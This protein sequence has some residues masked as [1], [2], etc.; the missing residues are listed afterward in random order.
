M[1]WVIFLYIGL[2]F[3]SVQL[4]GLETLKNRY[5]A[6]IITPRY[7]NNHTT[8][9]FS[10][11][12]QPITQNSLIDSIV[13]HEYFE[14]SSGKVLFNTVTNRIENPIYSLFEQQRESRVKLGDLHT[15]NRFAR[16]HYSPGK[17][18]AAR[19]LCWKKIH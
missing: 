13:Q 8:S 6:S 5:Q 15:Y 12:H 19:T 17:K 16:L 1:Y 7:H 2:Y 11:Q 3:V 9:Q 14:I 18:M 10:I 4:G